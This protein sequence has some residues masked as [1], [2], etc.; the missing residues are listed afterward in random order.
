[1]SKQRI[2]RTKNLTTFSILS[3]GLLI[4]TF[5]EVI[6]ITVKYFTNQIPVATITIKDT[7]GTPGNFLISNEQFF[8]PGKKVE[9]KAGYNSK[10]EKLFEGLVIKHKLKV[11]GGSTELF[12][13]IMDSV[14]QMAEGRKNNYF[15]DSSDSDIF[16]RLIKSYPNLQPEVSN[17]PIFH[18]EVVQYNCTDWDFLLTRARAIGQIVNVESGKVKIGPPNPASSTL[19]ELD[20]GRDVYQFEAEIDAQH[21]Y[22]AS[23]GVS[24]NATTQAINQIKSQ[25]PNLDR[26]GNSSGMD[27]APIIGVK[28][29]LLQH[30]GRLSQDELKSWTDSDHFYYRLSKIKGKISTSGN[31]QIKAGDW[32]NLNGFGE[33]F[34]GQTFIS[35]VVHEIFPSRGWTTHYNFGL[36]YQSTSK[37]KDSSITSLIPDIQGLHYGKVTAISQDPDQEFRVKVSL[38]LVSQSVEG[39]WAR[40]GNVDAGA[41][42]GFFFYPEIGDEVIVGFIDNDPRNMV[43]LGSL[44]SSQYPAPITPSE[45]NFVK[46]IFT[47]SGLKLI[48]EDQDITVKIETPKGNLLSISEK[49][50]GLLLQDQFGNQVKLGHQ[51]VSLESNSDI[52]I[53]ASGDIQIEG[54]N[55]EIN[56]NAQL[57]AKGS[58]SA[59]FESSGSTE[60]KGSII[61][62]N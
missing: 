52:S 48:F 4:P 21:Q 6:R 54:A 30:G 2:R 19:N 35:S 7:N 38:P 34:D 10:E 42:H 56:A 39:T 36:D 20:F 3:D 23:K 14:V 22:F 61:Q 44:F 9:I 57:K 12:L 58:A 55:I 59:K 25:E 32:I 24:W 17:S 37:P 8:A 60:I 46:G 49:E 40:L 27:L 47:K 31:A 5:M 33:R 18:R 62:I 11:S 13:E 29:N 45:D 53:K 26:Q 43:V 51:G 28:E 41:S 1:M 50:A 15:Y 16:Q